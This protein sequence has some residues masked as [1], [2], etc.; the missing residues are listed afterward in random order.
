MKIIKMSPFKKEKS[1]KQNVFLKAK[2]MT[3]YIAKNFGGKSQRQP[4]NNSDV[5]LMPHDGR[6]R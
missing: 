1:G 5:T 2:T 4:P 3:N 6:W